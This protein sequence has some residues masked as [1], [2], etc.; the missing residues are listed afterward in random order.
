MMALDVKNAAEGSKPSPPFK[1]RQ[2]RNYS[3]SALRE[4][5][6]ANIPLM[7]G[8]LSA[9]PYRPKAGLASGT[10]GHCG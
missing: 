5:E 4:V 6:K 9:R 10:G 1:G 2:F 8:R 3:I 7:V